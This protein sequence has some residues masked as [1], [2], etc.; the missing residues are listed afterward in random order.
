MST[1]TFIQQ[2]AP[3]DD[4]GRG[5]YAVCRSII[6]AF[7]DSL[8]K[9]VLT[10]LNTP[11]EDV[12]MR[13]LARV[14]RVERDT[15]MKGDGFEWAVHEAVVGREPMV[16]EILAE[17]LKRVSKSLK[18]TSEVNSVL[19]GYERAKYLGFLD[20]VVENAATE[21]VLL[22]DGSGHPYSF[23]TW[24]PVAA[25]GKIAEA[26]LGTRITQVWKTDLFLTNEQNRQYA[27][28]TVKSNW[29]QLEAGRGLRIGI[30][31]EA[32]GLPVGIQRRDGLWLAVLPDPDGFT[33]L[34]NDAYL[35]VAFAMQTLGQHQRI[36]YFAKPSAK[37]QRV[38]AQ[39]EKYP[40]AKVLDI[41]HALNEA[42]QQDLV[43]VEKKLLSVE[44]PPWLR[45]KEKNVPVVT[46]RPHFEPIT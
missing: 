24:V 45:M 12:T 9:D 10:D 37:A 16:T 38:Q 17:A 23:G 36:A 32:E 40:T 3:T 28:A 2:N 46:V 21:A 8:G 11:R 39:I 22:P 4:Y 42:A 33:G 14:A 25:K 30:V 27:A 35:A 41:D 29:E 18:S 6:R 7:Y 26:E 31:P 43:G 15:G 5:L 1:V 13:Q 20:A 44:L 19:F 34:F